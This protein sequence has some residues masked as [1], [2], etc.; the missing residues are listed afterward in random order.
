[1]SDMP[2]YDS[3][4]VGFEDHLDYVYADA[5]AGRLTPQAGLHGARGDSTGS[6]SRRLG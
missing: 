5:T 1:M 4:F 3:S 2:G 6:P